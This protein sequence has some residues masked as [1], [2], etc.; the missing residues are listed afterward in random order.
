KLHL[1]QFRAIIIA[2]HHTYRDAEAHV[3]G[4]A[5]QAGEDPALPSMKP[6]TSPTI[7]AASFPAAVPEDK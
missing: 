2:S 5:R 4:V 6:L 7:R 3:Q 1:L